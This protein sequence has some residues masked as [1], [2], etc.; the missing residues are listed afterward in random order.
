MKM[1]SVRLDDKEAGA[2]DEVCALLPRHRTP[3]FLRGVASSNFT[4][5]HVPEQELSTLAGLMDK[6]ADRPMDFADASL[7][8]LADALG[9]TDIATLDSGFHIYRPRRGRALRNRFS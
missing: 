4:L 3:L 7:L 9:I 5:V 6:Y 1:L 8:W 2:L